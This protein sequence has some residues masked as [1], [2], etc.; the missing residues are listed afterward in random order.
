[1]NCSIKDTDNAILI[2]K[3]RLQRWSTKCAKDKFKCH[4]NHVCSYRDATVRKY[5]YQLNQKQ[6]VILTRANILCV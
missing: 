2:D 4:G 1:M 3:K 5:N 6:F